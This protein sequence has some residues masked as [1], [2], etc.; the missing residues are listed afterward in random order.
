VPISAGEVCV[1]PPG[2]PHQLIN[3]G[4]EIL[5]V[6]IVADNPALDAFYY[7][8]SGHRSRLLGRRRVKAHH[9]FFPRNRQGKTGVATISR[10]PKSPM[11]ASTVASYHAS[12]TIC[13]CP[14]VPQVAPVC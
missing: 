10:R 5:E 7:P 12:S 9:P 1:H 4:P 11:P 6:M 3:S 8:L 2:E 13:Q 14:R